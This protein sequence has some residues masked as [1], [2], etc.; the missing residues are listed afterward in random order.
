M[1]ER[2]ASFKDLANDQECRELGKGQAHGNDLS[3]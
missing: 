1:L 2:I 3:S